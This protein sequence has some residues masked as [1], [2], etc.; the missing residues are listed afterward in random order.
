MS[1]KIMLLLIIFLVLPLAYSANVFNVEETG[2]VSLHAN[3]TDPDSDKL[4]T[5]YSA[6]LDE[7]GGWQTNYGD[8]GTYNSTI[9]VSDGTTSV[10]KDITIIVAKK[11]VSPEIQSFEPIENNLNIKEAESVNFKALAIDLNKD[12]LTYEW[13]LDDKKVKDGQEFSY[14]TT[15]NDAGSHKISVAVSDGTES[16]SKEWNVNVAKVDVGNLLYEIPD[17]VFNENE[18]VSLKLPDFEKYGLSYSISQPVGNN[19]EWKTTY[20]DAGTYDVTVH[21]AGKG[22]SGDKTVKV[23]V[24]NVDRAPVFDK[25]ENKVINEGEELKIVLHAADPD[26]DEITYSAS[27]MPEGA[28]LEGDTFA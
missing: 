15:Y 4:V 17:V 12:S 27:N 5:T 18:V 26:V 8:A 16:T 14:D 24:N 19:N 20:S 7:N 25:L 10:S 22:F 11:E 2:K 9:T 28:K 13:H 3:A 21:A 6:P 1:K 23:V